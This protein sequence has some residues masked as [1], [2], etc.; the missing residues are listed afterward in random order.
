MT[1]K[2][3]ILIKI[4]NINDEIGI[5]LIMNNSRD[6]SFFAFTKIVFRIIDFCIFMQLFFKNNI[7]HLIFNGK[8]KFY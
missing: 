3:K 5:T 4:D 2:C 8:F 7:K 6:R 1:Y